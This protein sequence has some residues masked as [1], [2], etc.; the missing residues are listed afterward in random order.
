VT[1]VQIGDSNRLQP[2]AGHLDFKGVFG[3]LRDV[4]YGGFLAMECTVA[5]DPRDALPAVS[6]FVRARL[7]PSA[8]PATERPDG[9]RHC[10][11]NA[12]DGLLEPPIAAV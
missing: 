9:D 6:R 7:D 8:S 5:G 2:G 1:H 3:A 11:E 10:R 4:D 12:Q